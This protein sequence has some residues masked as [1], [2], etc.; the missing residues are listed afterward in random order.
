MPPV[1]SLIQPLRGRTPGATSPGVTPKRS[2]SRSDAID[3]KHAIHGFIKT[4]S[5][6]PLGKK[7]RQRRTTHQN[8]NQPHNKFHTHPARGIQGTKDYTRPP[9]EHKNKIPCVLVWALK[10][11]TLQGS[12][13]LCVLHPISSGFI[14]LCRFSVF[15]HVIMNVRFRK[16][17]T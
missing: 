12:N 3:R 4:I 8:P 9:P 1:I 14:A 15:L 17:E 10:R 16:A 5:L 13:Q 11:R 6:N 2:I 7:D